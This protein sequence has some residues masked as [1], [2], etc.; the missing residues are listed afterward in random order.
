LVGASGSG[1]TTLLRLVAGLVEPTAG[2]IAVGD[3][4]V[5]GPGPDRALV[6]QHGG[7]YPWHTVAGNVRLALELSRTAEGPEAHAI[8]T[9][10]LEL[11]GLTEFADHYPGELSGGMQQRAALARALALSPTILLMDEPFGALDAITRRRL[12]EELLGI[13]EREQRTVLFV[14]HSID[15]A[16]LLADRVV[17]LRS[18]A[19]ADDVP[20]EIPR[21]RD[22]DAV[23]ED[24]TFIE[25]RRRLWDTL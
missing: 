13:W 7:L 15:E 3:R 2:S 22:A 17:L 25:L 18:G 24:S 8:V 12:A 1:K 9:E 23:A 19:I 16:L 4:P 20:V 21:P 5:S 14:T 6:F 10:Q 11:V